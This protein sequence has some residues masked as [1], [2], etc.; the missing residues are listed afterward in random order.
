MIKS[1]IINKSELFYEDK[2]DNGN[3]K[4][5]YHYILKNIMFFLTNNDIP[6]SVNFGCP[7]ISKDINL[8]FQYE[9]TIIK[10]DEDKCTCKIHR[11]YSLIKN[12]SI[13]EYSNANINHIKSFKKSDQYLNICHYYPPLL[14]NVTNSMDRVKNCLTIHSPSPRRD[15]IHQK[16]NMDYY[17]QVGIGDIYSKKDIKNVMD[18]YKLLVNIHQIETNLTLEELRVLPALMTGILIISEDVPY[19]EHIPYSKHIIFSPYDEIVETIKNVLNNYDFFRE[20][21]LYNLD[22]TINEMKNKSDKEM[23]SVFKNYIA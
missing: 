5:Y 17:H 2:W 19:K 22:D 13:F 10:K 6:Y 11:Y 20:K 3:L 18:N 15:N 23:E 14:Y 7:E 4:E 9:H 1:E 16:I 8:D 12:N 21:Y